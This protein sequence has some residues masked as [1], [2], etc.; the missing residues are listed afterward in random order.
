[1]SK[2]AVVLISMLCA[3]AALIAPTF[4]KDRPD[5]PRIGEKVDRICFASGINGFQTPKGFD[6]AVILTKGVRDKY[7]VELSG[8]GFGSLRFAQSV[9]IASRP[10]DGCVSR[11]DKLIFSDSAFGFDRDNR[12]NQNSYLITAIYE[13]NE[14]AAKQDESKDDA[15]SED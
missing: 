5:D 7:L 15:E 10:A 4:A 9:A 12:I 13:W 2:K 14:D 11:G 3:G 1:M 8:A 6:D